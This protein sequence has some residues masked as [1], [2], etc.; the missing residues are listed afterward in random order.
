VPAVLVYLELVYL[1]VPAIQIDTCGMHS[2][3]NL[4]RWDGDYEVNKYP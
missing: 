4:R 2:K 3:K 1:D